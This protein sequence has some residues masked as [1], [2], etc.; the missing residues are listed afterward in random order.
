M[1]DRITRIVEAK[2]PNP[3][4]KQ[5]KAQ[6]VKAPVPVKGF[7]RVTKNGSA[8]VKSF[9]RVGDRKLHQI[10]SKD[11]LKQ[12]EAELKSK[13]SG[14]LEELPHEGTLTKPLM[15]ENNINNIFSQITKG[16]S[17]ISGAGLSKE[18]Q[19]KIKTE[20]SGYVKKLDDTGMEF[21]TVV[22]PDDLPPIIKLPKKFESIAVLAKHHNDA[23]DSHIGY[24][25]EE[26]FVGEMEQ[27]AS[28]PMESLNS[29]L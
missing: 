2:P 8:T 16:A 7:T 29:F 11:T 17:K 26:H 15:S 4:K 20:V 19:G 3:I 9:I 18:L 21:K 22:A 24:D 1:F 12:L 6:K 5:L 27:I 23:E 13:N 28:Q 25:G 10:L 14:A